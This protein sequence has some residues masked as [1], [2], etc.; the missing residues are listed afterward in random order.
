[1]N[2]IDWPV[3]IKE[4]REKQLI[5]QQELAEQLGVSFVTVN[6]WENSHYHPTMKQRRVLHKLFK[7][8]GITGE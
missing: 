6:R 7:E 2:K 5:T 1:M 3:L 4:Y 8:S